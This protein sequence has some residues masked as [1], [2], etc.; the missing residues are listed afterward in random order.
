KAN[1]KPQT[2]QPQIAA[3]QP[4]CRPA[5]DERREQYRKGVVSEHAPHLVSPWK[6]RQMDGGNLVTPQP[7]GMGKEYDVQDDRRQC[8]PEASAPRRFCQPARALNFHHSFFGT[9]S[10]RCKSRNCLSATSVGDSVIKSAPLA[11]FGNAI[12]SRMLG[13]P[14]KIAMSRSKPSAMPPCG[15]AP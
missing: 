15:G 9:F 11:V 3:A 10:S 12:T 6:I 7:A 2:P 8:G 14:H 5:P 4:K 13:V 1:Q